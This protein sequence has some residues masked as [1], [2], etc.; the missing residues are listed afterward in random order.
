MAR[1]CTN[2]GVSPFKPRLAPSL[3]SRVTASVYVFEFEALL[4]IYL[5]QILY[6]CPWIVVEY[7]SSFS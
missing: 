7:G 2:V 4:S 1:H 3:R 6:V 5:D